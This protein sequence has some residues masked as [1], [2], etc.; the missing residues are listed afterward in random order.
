MLR[1]DERALLVDL[2][3]PPDEGYRLE[4]AIGTTFTMHLESLLRIPLAVVGAEWRDS[5]DPLGVMEA[6]RSTADRIDVFC[7]AGMLAVPSSPS[8]L[9]AFLEPLVHQVERPQPGHLF[10]PKM[11]LASFL[12]PNRERRFRFLCGSRNLTED[13]AWD[14]VIAITGSEG[15]SRRAVNRPL[16]EFL[17]SLPP[18]VV[19]GIPDERTA[20]IADLAEAV[21]Y[22]IWEPPE[23]VVD[24]DWLTFHWID[25]GRRFSG[26]FA[27]RNHRVVISPFLNSQ[28]ISHVWPEGSCTVIS[29]AEAF[30]GLGD[31]YITRLTKEWGAELF[32]LDE[33][34]AFPSDE[35]DALI[36]RW[37]LRGLHAKVVVIDRGYRSHLF[38]GSA[39]ATEAAWSG[40]T[41]LVVEVVGPR[42]YFGTNILLMD[43]EGGFSSV[44]RP[45][46]A[47]AGE[48]PME[49]TLQEQLEWALVDVAALAFHGT[50]KLDANELWT[51]HL[52]TTKAAPKAFPGSATLTV[53]PLTVTKALSVAVGSKIDGT[54]EGLASEDITPFFALELTAGPASNR[55]RAACVVLADLTGGPTDRIDRL[56][57]RQVG[58]PEA[59][60]RFL[61]L[62]LQLGR[63]ETTEVAAFLGSDSDTNRGLF[64]WGTAGVFE[65]LVLALAEHPRAIDD[66]DE[67]VTRLASTDDGRAVLPP[68]W[69]DLWSQVLEAKDTI[70]GV[71]K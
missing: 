20:A 10:H 28:G 63:G 60:L 66:V 4:R 21:R 12:H 56:I 59:F 32:E 3:T 14:A 39:N 50:A 11:W 17:A 16:G 52:E 2:L 19:N 58:S 25:R 34:A 37:S 6:I 46:V 26:D 18:R 69:D 51:E 35:D 38:I 36:P 7:Q 8:G 71:T 64:N 27:G 54:W 13:R 30:A 61:L 45:H 29:R 22:A 57:A 42:K 49:P 31:E 68:G 23:G 53:R 41:E 43:K 67:L 44:L 70:D 48:S 33:D 24:D 1:T 47:Q 65:S 5:A 62:L 15:A 9:L 40:N 55:V